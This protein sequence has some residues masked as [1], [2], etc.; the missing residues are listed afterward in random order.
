MTMVSY[1]RYILPYV[2]WRTKF[3]FILVIANMYS[4]P[5]GI[6]FGADV[7]QPYFI[8]IISTCL[9]CWDVNSLHREN[10]FASE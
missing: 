1:S 8:H 9:T 2:F 10:I 7:G 3:I 4:I 6:M 5:L